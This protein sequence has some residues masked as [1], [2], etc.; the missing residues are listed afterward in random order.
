[1]RFYVITFVV[2]DA[3]G[4]PKLV[5]KM[6]NHPAAVKAVKGETDMFP[7]YK[8]RKLFSTWLI[9]PRGNGDTLNHPEY[10]VTCITGTEHPRVKEIH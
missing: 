8:H 2:H 4:D 10:V 6:C 7:F 5:T 3:D 1:M 9:G